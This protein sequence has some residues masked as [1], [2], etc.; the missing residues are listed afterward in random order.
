MSDAPKR[1]R[2]QT[3]ANDNWRPRQLRVVV[4]VPRMLPI[5]LVEIEVFAEL[6]DT[7]PEAANDNEFGE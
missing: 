2:R 4:N 5:Q 1:A 3:P 7:L 6:L